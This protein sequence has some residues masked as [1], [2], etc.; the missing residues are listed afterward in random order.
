MVAGRLDPAGAPPGRGHFLKGWVCALL[1]RYAAAEAAAVGP[2]IAGR[3]VLDLGAA[4]N[5]VATA[6]GAN[7]AV[8]A[9]GADVGAHRRA[10]GPYVVYDGA[11]LPFGDGAFDTTL[12]LLTLHHCERP[13]EVLD[14]AVRV[15]RRRLIVTESVWRTRTE[16]FWLTVLDRPVNRFR[17][18]GGMAPARH[19]RRPE[20]WRDLFR[21]R[22]LTITH[23]R[24]LGGWFERLA[25]H[26]L[27]FV[28]DVGA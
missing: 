2:H 24:W 17:H 13:D 6:L 10:G 8:W 9:C 7:A 18:G 20:Q 25:H 4:E 26:P 23:E 15:T 21:R 28:L 19:V 11:P 22:G 3:R 1:R 5:W 12:V 16:R 14:E 27:L